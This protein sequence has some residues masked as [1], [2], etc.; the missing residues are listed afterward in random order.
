MMDNRHYKPTTHR[1]VQCGELV[2]PDVMILVVEQDV[3]S[4]VPSGDQGREGATNV[5]KRFTVARQ[6]DACDGL[7]QRKQ[8]QTQCVN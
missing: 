1:G 3:R 2:K 7:L 4:S 6:R 5:C 8:G